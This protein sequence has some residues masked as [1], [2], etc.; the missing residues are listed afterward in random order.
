[1]DDVDADNED[2]EDEDEDQPSEI[3]RCICGHQDLQLNNVHAR[4]QV[5]VSLFIQCD[6]CQVWQHGYCV[7]IKT[8]EDAPQVYYCERCRPDYH[9][10]V[11]RPNGKTSKY[12]PQDASDEGEEEEEQIEEE[13]DQSVS[14]ERDRRDKSRSRK[15]NDDSD[16]RDR[17]LSRR[18]R[19]EKNSVVIRVLKSAA[20]VPKLHIP[21]QTVGT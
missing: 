13:E 21:C 19:R 4:D 18:E 7:G 10:I 14:K 8:S 17:L 3:T 15:D 9:V 6:K 20:G 12:S 11:V 16:S 1:M 2:E 5:D